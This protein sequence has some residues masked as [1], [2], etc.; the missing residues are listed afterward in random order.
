VLVKYGIRRNVVGYGKWYPTEALLP[1]C[2]E[3]MGGA[4]AD[5]FGGRE[6]GS[7]DKRVS[8]HQ[9]LCSARVRRG[10]VAGGQRSPKGK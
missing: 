8:R 6:V 7:S 4:D 3:A 1:S 10:G 2:V 5:V 9:K